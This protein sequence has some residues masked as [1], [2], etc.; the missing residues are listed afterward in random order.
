MTSDTTPPKDDAA[1]MPHLELL[2][3]EL[4]DE[5]LVDAGEIVYDAVMLRV[6]NA[7]PVDKQQVLTTM[8]ASGEVTD[9]Q[10]LAFVRNEVP[11][12][13]SFVQE[14]VESLAR[15]VRDAA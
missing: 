9:E 11:D 12:L 3:K 2:P 4:E 15:T 8:L 5:L 7:L 14:E 13:D 6:F 1:N 10:V